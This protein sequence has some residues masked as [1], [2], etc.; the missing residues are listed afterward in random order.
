MTL[1]LISVSYSDKVKSIA[2]FAAM[3][4]CAGTLTW[5][6]I[7]AVLRWSFTGMVCSG[8]FYIT[9]DKKVIPYQWQTGLFMKIYLCVSIL[10][11]GLGACCGALYGI[12]LTC[13]FYGK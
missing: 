7:G 10:V 11:L 12:A 8:D 13:G 2:N 1:V 5:V 9:T 6:I 3:F 4:T